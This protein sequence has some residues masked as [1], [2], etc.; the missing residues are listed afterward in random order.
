VNRLKAEGKRAEK[1]KV[2][3]LPYCQLGDSDNWTLTDGQV[4]KLYG[5]T[6]SDRTAG[7]VFYNGQI[8]SADEFLAA[9]KNGQNLLYVVDAQ[10]PGICG[11]G[12]LNR[13]E[14]K[15]AR[16]HFTGFSNCWGQDSVAI[17]REVL[18]QLIHQ[19]DKAGYVFDVF[20]G[21]TPSRYRLALSFLA[22]V[23][24]R[25]VGEIPHACW[26]AKRQQAEPGM[27][28]YYVRGTHEEDL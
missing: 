20:I 26:N 25:T 5:I 9:M 3:L 17:C 19:R 12:W 28:S 16:I 22:K 8:N 18:S 11:M 24:M 1:I 10:G 27:L 21:I 7:I 13:F 23:G 2:T 6:I 14:G 15:T 4:R